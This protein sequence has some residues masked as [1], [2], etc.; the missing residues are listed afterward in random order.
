MLYHNV[1][2]RMAPLFQADRTQ[3]IAD[4]Q[5]LLPDLTASSSQAISLTSVHTYV[6]GGKTLTSEKFPG[7]I[8][9]AFV[10]HWGVV[11]GNTL[12]HLVFRDPSHA[13]VN[14]SDFSR[15]GK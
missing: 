1:Y 12:Y 14:T 8:A 15:E 13:E 11:V 4:A 10:S 3:V 9:P 5:K 7:M 6:A 2:Q